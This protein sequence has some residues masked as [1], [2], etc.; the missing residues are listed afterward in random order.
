LQSHGSCS[1][2]KE[3][4]LFGKNPCLRN[5]LYWSC[6]SPEKPCPYG[7]LVPKPPAPNDANQLF[8]V[9]LL[10]HAPVCR[11]LAAGIC[12]GN[13]SGLPLFL[14]RLLCGNVALCLHR[15][16]FPLFRK[17]MEHGK[18]KANFNFLDT[19]SSLKPR[20]R[21]L[22]QPFRSMAEARWLFATIGLAAI[23]FIA[24]LTQ[25]AKLFKQENKANWLVWITLLAML[26]LDIVLLWNY[27]PV[28]P[29]IIWNVPV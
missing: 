6:R 25:F 3:K 11:H 16:P 1:S 5:P 27:N 29:D 28:L 22:P 8:P 18:K 4:R 17:R 21:D 13:N 9:H 23:L 10:L 15:L 24:G 20:R 7:K 12:H 2:L 26:A 19:A 14:L